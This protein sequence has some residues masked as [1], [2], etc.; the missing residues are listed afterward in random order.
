MTETTA[1]DTSKVSS[2]TPPAV[3]TLG[4]A[5]QTLRDIR[6]EQIHDLDTALKKL[7]EERKRF[8]SFTPVRVEW[9]YL[10]ERLHVSFFL[11]ARNCCK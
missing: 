4:S 10:R 6:E 7:A 11:G 9:Y 5:H 3:S 2:S 1:Y 8:Y